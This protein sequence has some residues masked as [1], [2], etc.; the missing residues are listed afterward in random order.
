MSNK[1]LAGKI[2]LVTGASR[3]IGAAVAQ[4][5]AQAGAHVLLVARK[6]ALLEE[7]DDQ[8][9][10]LG[11]TAT[12][13]PCDLKESSKIA[14]MA[15]LVAKRFGKTDI[16][17]GNAAIL[18]ELAPINSI[19]P[20]IHQEVM[21]INVT[22]NLNLVRYFHDLLRQ[23]SAP[24]VIF[25][26]SGVGSVARPFWSSYAISK[27]ALEMMAKIYAEEN[28]N[29]G[30]KVNLVNPGPT[31][32]SMR[33]AAM[34]GEDPNILKTPNMITKYFIDLAKDECNITGTVVNIKENR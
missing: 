22:A 9:R 31:R 30:F 33:A 27:A 5:Y 1:I 26:T 25:V 20:K 18:G 4:A 34:P 6:I 24:R 19:D 3:G 28:V 8:I 2:A 7:V 11:G 32:T 23:S 13:V 17:V 16:L 14:E 15:L 12:I 10:K 29:F 21:D